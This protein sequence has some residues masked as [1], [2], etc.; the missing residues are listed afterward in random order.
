MKSGFPGVVSAVRAL[1]RN[2][3]LVMM[4]DVFDD[5]AHTLTVPF[6]GRILRVAPGTAYFALR[7]SAWVV[8]VFAAPAPRLGVRVSIGRPIDPLRFAMHDQSQAIFMLTRALFASFEREIRRTPEHWHHWET[9]P[10]VSTSVEP[11]GRLED[12]APLRLLRDKC[13]VSP[14]LLEDVPELELLVK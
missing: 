1:A 14:Y 6:Y 11:P 10:D 3:Y 9:F 8:P 12:D 2:E 5:L 7:T 4:P 13:E